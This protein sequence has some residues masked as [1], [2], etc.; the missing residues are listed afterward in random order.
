MLAFLFS[1]VYSTARGNDPFTA[2]PLTHVN[3]DYVE[4]TI[5][6]FIPNITL[7]YPCRHYKLHSDYAALTLT[8]LMSSGSKW[9]MVYRMPHRGLKH[10]V[11]KSCMILFCV[12]Q[13]TSAS[14]GSPYLMAFVIVDCL[15]LD[16]FSCDEVEYAVPEGLIRIT[17]SGWIDFTGILRNA[18]VAII[19]SRN[20]T[21]ILTRWCWVETC[22]LP[23]N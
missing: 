1:V 5:D 4:H 11:P 19:F 16:W 18:N 7:T 9:L 15:R 2:S 8:L 12:M 14:R 22:S 6:S 21:Q 3:T 17:L 20:E 23:C 10:S 13:S